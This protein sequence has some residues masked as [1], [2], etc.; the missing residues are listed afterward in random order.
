MTTTKSKSEK[1]EKAL[2]FVVRLVAFL[3]G[4]LPFVPNALFYLDLRDEKL[5][6]TTADGIFILIGFVMLWGSSHF[7]H[8]ANELGSGIVSK[9]KKKNDNL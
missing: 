9:I 8:W 4:F 1:S 7:G 2:I 5:P 6:I 3:I